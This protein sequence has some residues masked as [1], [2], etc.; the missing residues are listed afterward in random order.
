MI[1]DIIKAYIENDISVSHIKM[2]SQSCKKEIN[3]IF[4]FC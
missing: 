3:E 1:T 4:K 2:M